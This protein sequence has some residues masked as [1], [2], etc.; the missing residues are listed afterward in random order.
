VAVGAAVQGG[1]L[2]G[3]VKDVLLLDVTPL[4]LGIETLGGVMT[5]LIQRNTT[6]P[7]RKSEIFSTAVDNQT[8]VE[9][10]VLQG[11]RQLARDNRT[12]GRFHLT[13]LAAAPRGVPQIEVAFDIDANGIVS[14]TAKDQATGKEQKI[15]ITASS[16]L[17]KDEV[18]RLVKDA[19]SHAADDKQRREFIDAKNQADSLAYQVE[20]T[21]N[22]HREKLPVGD[23]SRVEAA[24]AEVRKRSDGDDLQALRKAIDDLQHAS[25][26][27]AQT[28]YANQNASS[29]STGSSGPG[30]N[31]KD[32][33]VINAEYQETGA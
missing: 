15:T 11:E 25:H 29:G 9:V 12:L 7:S 24:I 1:V 21:I 30:S 14:V 3:E 23:L 33:E 10:H 5:T 20:K 31:V 22:E 13:G 32:G 8:S 19:Q 17:S 27:I 2:A 26:A 16:G 18:D 4:S 6:I 28:L